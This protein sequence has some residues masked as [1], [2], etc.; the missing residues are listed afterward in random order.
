MDL[1]ASSRLLKAAFFFF[2]SALFC[3]F[4]LA[5]RSFMWSLNSCSRSL[6]SLIACSVSLHDLLHSLS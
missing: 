1:L 6:A 3:S 4:S 2:C 5:S